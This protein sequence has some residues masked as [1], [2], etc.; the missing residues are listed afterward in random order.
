MPDFRI[1]RDQDPLLWSELANNREAAAKFSASAKKPG[2]DAKNKSGAVKGGPGRETK[3]ASSGRREG[4]AARPSGEAKGAALLGL[5]RTLASGAGARSGER[6]EPVGLGLLNLLNASGAVTG[7]PG[8]ETKADSGGRREGGAARPSGE[9]KGAGL[10]RLSRTLNSGA[11]ARSGGPVRGGVV[12]LGARSLS[13]DGKADGTG[14]GPRLPSAVQLASRQSQGAPETGAA[15]PAVL[16]P[17]TGVAG[18]EGVKSESV[19]SRPQI[20]RADFLEKFKA[21]AVQSV[22]EQLDKQAGEAGELLNRLTGSRF[23]SEDRQALERSRERI[24]PIDAEIIRKKRAPAQAEGERLNIKPTPLF[25]GPSFHTEAALQAMADASANVDRIKTELSSLQREREQAARDFPLLLRVPPEKMD[26][27]FARPEDQQV[28]FM[29]NEVMG[30][31]EA[32][33]RIRKGLTNGSINPLA[34]DVY[35]TPKWSGRDSATSSANGWRNRPPTSAARMRPWGWWKGG[36]TVIGSVGTAFT[37]GGLSLGLLGA[38]AGL[39]LYG[40]VETTKDYL[41]KNA[42]ANT[43]LDPNAGLIP[44]DLKG[45]WGWVA[46]GWIGVGLDASA[47]YGAVRAMQKGGDF[48]L[49]AKLLGRS[50]TEVRAG[51]HAA[52]GRITHHTLMGSREFDERFQRP[53]ANAVTLLRKGEDGR[54]HAEII[55]R[56]E[57]SKEERAAA[58]T[59]EF[60]HVEQTGRSELRPKLEKITEDQLARWPSMSGREKLEAYQAKLELE[61]D[62][63]TQLIAHGASSATRDAAREA[64]EGLQGKLA[65]VTDDLKASETP[66]WKE[67]QWL[68]DAEPPRLFSDSDKTKSTAAAVA[69]GHP[70][71]KAQGL[72]KQVFYRRH[73]DDFTPV[74]FQGQNKGYRWKVV[75]E[76]DDG[77]RAIKRLEKVPAESNPIQDRHDLIQDAIQKNPEGIADTELKNTVDAVIARHEASLGAFDARLKNSYRQKLEE[78]KATG[79]KVL[80]DVEPKAYFRAYVQEYEKSFTK[81]LNEA[82]NKAEAARKVEE[83]LSEAA[84]KGNFTAM[85]ETIRRGQRKLALEEISA[86]AERAPAGERGGGGWRCCRSFSTRSPTTARGG[87]C[88]ASSA[89][90]TCRPAWKPSRRRRGTSRSIE[91]VRSD[92]KLAHADGV[93][94]MT[95]TPNLGATENPIPRAKNIREDPNLP[96]EKR[97][98]GLFLVEDKS[99]DAFKVKQAQNYSQN[100]I[101]DSIMARSSR[102]QME[103]N[104]RG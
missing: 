62:A 18:A 61:I 55:T 104:L 19:K 75:T 78:A 26:E 48:S 54:I 34:L 70:D 73:G 79:A 74:S 32:I 53:S 83:I 72:E 17:R 68:R 101:D 63:Q 92:K 57:L 80:A 71:P 49:A 47:V 97:I 27:F 2:Q 103:R 25:K 36:L 1:G 4:G 29:H 84:S 99:G 24:A 43:A 3:T 30:V 91:P 50:E 52:E 89:S 23:R 13:A 66:G 37:S 67:P 28:K 100:L 86:G 85:E 7:E 94:R 102:R 38:S 69:A 65:K 81:I 82:G 58:L 8:R 90:R 5:S 21:N 88:S 96:E 20:S 42:E 64:R 35:G 15:S 44:Q 95:E 40:T 45:H 39:G 98:T 33:P 51:V 87:R 31:L 41:T 16:Q 6:S 14:A 56:A 77:G 22:T 46:A 59:E 93:V 76:V 9:A 60:V 10:L 12:G 11:G